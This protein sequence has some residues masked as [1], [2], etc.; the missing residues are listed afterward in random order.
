M[1]CGSNFPLEENRFIL[2]YGVSNIFRN[3]GS[4]FI[5]FEL[6]PDWSEHWVYTKYLKKFPG[7]KM[8]QET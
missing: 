5:N 8:F 6:A 7:Y 3:M 4:I 2:F 1:L